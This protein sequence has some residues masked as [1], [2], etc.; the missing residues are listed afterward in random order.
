MGK[1]ALLLQSGVIGGRRF[2]PYES[3]IPFLL[4]VRT[5]AAY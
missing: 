2:Q 3:H 4:Q 5:V 1:V